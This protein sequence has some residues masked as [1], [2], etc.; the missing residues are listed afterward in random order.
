MLDFTIAPAGGA[1]RLLLVGVGVGE[2][3]GVGVGEA[4][5]AGVAEG[6]GVGD[7]AGAVPLTV[8]ERDWLETA[9]VESQALITTACV[10]EPTARLVL[11]LE[12][13]VANTLVLSM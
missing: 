6:A 12:E 7:G 1:G 8:I 2:A 5:G 4:V 11:M 9:P 3:F 13:L 10:P